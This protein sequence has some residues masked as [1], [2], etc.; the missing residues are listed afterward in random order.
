MQANFKNKRGKTI[1]SIQWNKPADILAWAKGLKNRSVIYSPDSTVPIIIDPAPEFKEVEKLNLRVPLQEATGNAIEDL[2]T[3]YN[4]LQK[5]FEYIL[6]KDY[7]NEKM[8]ESKRK[9]IDSLKFIIESQYD[10]LE[11]SV[12]EAEKFEKAELCLINFGVSELEYRIF[13]GRSLETINTLMAIY[14]EENSVQMP[15]IFMNVGVKG[16]G[17]KVEVPVLDWN[18]IISEKNN[19]KN[20]LKYKT[21]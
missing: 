17:A 1:L 11:A 16:E 10:I 8:L 14:K 20:V 15:A 7:I 19:L 4:S 12:I 3:L 9:Q 21:K 18:K 2:K 5:E 13:T 6:S